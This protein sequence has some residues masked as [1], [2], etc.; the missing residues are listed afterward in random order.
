M[1]K[2]GKLAHHQVTAAEEEVEEKEEEE[3][4]K[5]VEEEAAVVLK[6]SGTRGCDKSLG[7]RVNVSA[8]GD[9]GR[10]NRCR[11]PPRRPRL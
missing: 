3:E 11:G 7:Q 9:R 1:G 6:S 8:A 2:L 10:R 4:E 5:K